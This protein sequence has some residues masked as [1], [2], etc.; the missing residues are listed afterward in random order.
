MGNVVFIND[1]NNSGNLG[2]YK[3][4]RV[5]QGVGRTYNQKSST[6]NVF[7]I[8]KQNTKIIWERSWPMS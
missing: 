5:S 7:S 1:P 4:Y 3:V 6:L 8:L 2:A